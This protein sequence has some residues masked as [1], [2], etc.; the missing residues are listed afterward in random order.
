MSASG[1]F[2]LPHLVVLPL[3]IRQHTNEL[4]RLGLLGGGSLLESTT[5]PPQQGYSNVSNQGPVKVLIESMYSNNSDIILER[6]SA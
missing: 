1:Y 5:Y 4:L 3:D 2:R 6:L